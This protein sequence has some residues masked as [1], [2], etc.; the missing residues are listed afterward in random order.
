MEHKRIAITDFGS[1][2]VMALQVV[3]T[4]LPK[5]GEVLIKVAFASVNPIDVKTR[6]GLGWAA[7]HNIDHLPW[8]P[9]Y[10]LSGQV[11]SCGANTSRFKVGDKVAGCIGFPFRGGSYSQ[12]VCVPETEVIQVPSSVSLES[13]AVL[14]LAGLTALQA[15][16][17]A[18]LIAGE[19][20]LILGGAGGVGHF[21]TQIAV[22]YQ[23]EVFATCR[24]HNID[25]INSLGARAL[26]YQ[27]SPV[28]ECVRN[29]DVLIDLVGGDTALAALP[30][31]APNARVI[32]LP[33]L[34]A[35]FVCE[36]A[37]ELGFTAHGMLVEPERK[38]LQQ[39]LDM[40]QR[41]EMKTEIQ[42]IYSMY[43]VSYAHKQVESG[44]TRG[45]VL[46]DMEC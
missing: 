22:T 29:I 10:D 16:Q 44:R 45:K 41:G 18:H 27:S 42:Q 19:R 20:V 6:A 1:V 15:L 9:G 32:T 17:K 40:L 39:L 7:A 30:C 46:L 33:T 12:Y 24:A 4:S 34:S 23:A 25:F 8:V 5:E 37:K 35:E 11:V 13:A 28:S 31:L 38:Q 43:D 2:D 14:P 21:A 3:S 26:N 36:H